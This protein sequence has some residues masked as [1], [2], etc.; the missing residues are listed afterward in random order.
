MTKFK[1]FSNP[2]SPSRFKPSED[3]PIIEDEIVLES[4]S[5][6]TEEI[7]P[8]NEESNDLPQ[9]KD[10]LSFSNNN[11]DFVKPLGQALD[12]QFSSPKRLDRLNCTRIDDPEENVEASNGQ[13]MKKLTKS[14][15]G[16]ER[17]G[18]IWP[19]PPLHLLPQPGL[20]KPNYPSLSRLKSDLPSVSELDLE[21][22]INRRRRPSYVKLV[23]KQMIGILVTIWVRRSLRKHI[24]N[25]NVS[26]V[27]VGIMGYVGNK[28]CSFSQPFD[29]QKQAA[30]IYIIM[31]KLL[32]HTITFSIQIL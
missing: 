1:S 18:L 14:L 13:Y 26:K 24:Q 9:N 27:G 32:N 11:D 21:S 10:D 7:Y 31:I 22:V 20:E 23:S 30:Y 17:M 2:P 29:L 15:S 5:D 25:L 3:A 4:D 8:V 28:V 12:R 16:T 19:E 6:V